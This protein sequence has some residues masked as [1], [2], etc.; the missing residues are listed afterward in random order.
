MFL[1]PLF[2][3]MSPPGDE[4]TYYLQICF[5]LCII[6]TFFFSTKKICIADC[7]GY[8]PFL[9]IFVFLMCIET[10][11]GIDNE[12]Y[13]VSC[14]LLIVG[15]AVFFFLSVY[16]ACF[17]FTWMFSWQRLCRSKCCTINFLGACKVLLFL[18]V[19]LLSCTCSQLR[20]DFTLVSKYK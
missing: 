13:F 16:I 3:G 12:Y 19:L 9:D 1:F 15:R 8:S 2:D 18:C 11:L 5:F 14:D 4:L 7:L 6:S 17:L 20:M 10:C